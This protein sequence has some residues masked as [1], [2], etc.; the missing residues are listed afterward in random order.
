V[1][2][3]FIIFVVTVGLAYQEY[4]SHFGATLNIAVSYCIHLPT[5]KKNVVPAITMPFHPILNFPI[6]TPVSVS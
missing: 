1:Y 5:G 4:N 6:P 2:I 3:I